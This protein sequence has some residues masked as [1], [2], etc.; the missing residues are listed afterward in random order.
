[1]SD[2]LV[3]LKKGNN[4]IVTQMVLAGLVAIAGMI[5]GI[6]MLMTQGGWLN[7][8]PAKF[9]Q[10]LTIHGTNMIRAAALAA[11]AILWYFFNHY[12]PLTKGIIKTQ[13]ILFVISAIMVTFGE[14]T[15]EY[16]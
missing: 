4:L 11:S 2:S 8:G 14:F 7:T 12:V 9:Y 3:K 10:L 16:D 15:V 1:M 5:F 6:L 13:L